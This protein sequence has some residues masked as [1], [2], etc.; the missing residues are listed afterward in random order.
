M[1]L[2]VSNEMLASF[3]AED[4]EAIQ[5]SSVAAARAEDAA[6]RAEGLG[7]RDL[8]ISGFGV[9]GA[10]ELAEALRM[11]AQRLRNLVEA[12]VARL[13]KENK[14]ATKAA[15]DAVAA[16]DATERVAEE[17]APT[18]DDVKPARSRA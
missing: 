5:R 14:A 11:R 15:T 16:V 18:D 3:P 9:V 2:S 12:R 8:F 10:Q 4:V 17:E 13:V 6:Q 7:E 1:T